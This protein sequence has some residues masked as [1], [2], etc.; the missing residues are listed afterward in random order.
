MSLD[1]NALAAE[2]R[3]HL[4]EEIVPFWESLKD[5][6]QG[7]YYGYMGY[8]LKVDRQYEKGC[9]LNSRILWFFS[10][11][12]LALKDPRLLEDAAHAYTFLKKYCVDKEFGGIY[13]SVTFDGKPKD[14]TKHTY[15][16]AFV[17]YALSSYYDASGDE[18]ALKLAED[19][20]HLIEEKCTD[21]YGYLE[22]FDRAFVPAEN[23]KLSENGVLAEK[24]MNTLL[25][26]FEA[27]TEF[28]RVSHKK[29]A[30]DRIR[31]MLD[32]FA[33]KVYN[34]ALGRQEVFFDR[35]WNSLID[36][37]SYGHDIE[38]AW[39]VDRGLEILGDPA[40]T[41]RISPI[42]AALTENIYD[43]AYKNHSLLNEAENGIPDTTRVWWVQA[44]AI[45]GFVNGY[46]K[47]PEKTC[48]LEA[49]RDIWEYICEYV[50]DRRKGSE[51]FWA[52]DENGKPLEKPIVEPWKCPYHNGR[53]C[54]EV[55]KRLES[56]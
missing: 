27:Y 16:Q 49:A 52:V 50:K 19:L 34:P 40:Y 41:E 37:Y 15:N 3:R 18:E 53:M 11:A 7:G 21:E 25:H 26:V 8:D 20:Y 14:T 5:V 10:N 51:W 9:I 12:Y 24:T 48:Y 33:D 23:D 6:E 13:W 30:A 29:E 54:M 28:Y 39:L 36:L 43:R 4:T 17:I 56:D 1:M 47:N 45:V 46:Q 31:F 55:M 42:T 35:E 2:V 22:A 32:I 38:T 44:E